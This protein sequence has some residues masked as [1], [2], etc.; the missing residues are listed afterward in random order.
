MLDTIVLLGHFN[1]YDSFVYLDRWLRLPLKY[2]SIYIYTYFPPKEWASYF[3]MSLLYSIFISLFSPSRL[4][5][6]PL[7]SIFIPLPSL[8]SPTPFPLYLSLLPC[9]SS[10]LSLPKLLLSSPVL[11]LPYPRSQNCCSPGKITLFI[12]CGE[13]FVISRATKL[14]T[15]N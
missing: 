10:M 12:L 4:P 9:S 15:Q 3:P 1:G 13:M 5:T 7:P 11:L 6:S 8:F 14:E 2:I